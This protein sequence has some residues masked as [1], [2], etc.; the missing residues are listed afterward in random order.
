M[1][2][3]YFCTII[4]CIVSVMTELLY[5]MSVPVDAVVQATA[6]KHNYCLLFTSLYLYAIK[7]YF[8]IQSRVFRCDINQTTLDFS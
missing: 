4:I 3:V 2:D 5:L 6:M 1:N 7:D 8:G